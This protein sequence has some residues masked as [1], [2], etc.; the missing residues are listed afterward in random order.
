MAMRMTG[1]SRRMKV[2]LGFAL[3]LLALAGCTKTE[4]AE[5]PLE[6]IPTPLPQNVPLIEVPPPPPVMIGEHKG[7]DMWHLRSGL[8][9]AVLLCQGPENPAMV[10][11][12]NRMLSTHRGLLAEAAQIQVDLFRAKGGK[13]WQDAHD[14][15]MTRIYNSYSNT[16]TREKFCSSAK[17]ILAEVVG[18]T[19]LAFSDKATTLLWEL[20][21]AANLPDPDGSLA[22]S[23]TNATP[24]APVGTQTVQAIGPLAN[25]R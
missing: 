20:N 25:P 23:G 1:T 7:Q 3:P 24:L 22:R 2:A 21:K 4:V 9:V 5:A 12:Y 10:A 17:T 6:N 11:D 14:D 13:K 15:H 19:P 18:A 16:S 8:N